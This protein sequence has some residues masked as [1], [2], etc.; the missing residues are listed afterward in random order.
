MKTTLIINNTLMAKIKAMAARQ[1]LT[2]S[3][4]VESL[5]RGALEKEQDENRIAPEIPTFSMGEAFVDI[6]DRDALFDLM[7]KKD[8]KEICSS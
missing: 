1:G 7:E 4:K 8:P 3:R 6:N 2:L 5:L